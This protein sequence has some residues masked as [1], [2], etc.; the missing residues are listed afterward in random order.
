MS[1][2]SLKPFEMET[3][4]L[5]PP[6]LAYKSLATSADLM[7]LAPL[8]LPSIAS[9]EAGRANPS[10]L[11]ITGTSKLPGQGRKVHMTE[12]GEGGALKMYTFQKR[13]GQ[14]REI[15]PGGKLSHKSGIK[16]WNFSVSNGQPT[17]LRMSR[18]TTAESEAGFPGFSASNSKMLMGGLGKILAAGYQDGGGVFG[19]VPS[20]HRKRAMVRFG[21]GSMI[22]GYQG[23]TLGGGGV[24]PRLDIFDAR[25]SSRAHASDPTSQAIRGYF[26]QQL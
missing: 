13:G 23:G 14:W 8:P 25:L 24:G 15:G 2:Y 1:Q 9:M 5:A 21:Y 19:G 20:K 3:G 16:V 7:E 4:M 6:G 26:R 12:I 10:Q 11:K 17:G 22:P 18:G